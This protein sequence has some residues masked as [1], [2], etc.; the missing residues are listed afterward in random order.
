[1]YKEFFEIG[2]C[3]IDSVPRIGLFDSTEN[4]D[5]KLKSH[6]YLAVF[7]DDHKFHGILTPFDLLE[8]PY[9]LVVDCLSPKEH[10][11]HSDSFEIILEKFKKSKCFAL[12]VFCDND[13]RGIIEKERVLNDFEKKLKTYH[14]KSQESEEIK[15]SF[16]YNLSHEV[17]TPLNGIIG[18]MEIIANLEKEDLFEKRAEYL[19]II[20]NSASRFLLVMD[21]V[22]LLSKLTNGVQ[23]PLNNTKVKIEKIFSELFVYFK[24]MTFFGPKKPEIEYINPDKNK[25]III[26]EEKLKHILYHLIDNAIK[27]SDDNKAIF[28]YDISDDNHGI[29]FFVENHY[30]KEQ[31]ING[32][33]E[34]FKEFYKQPEIN[35]HINPGFGIGLSLVKRLT[36]LLGGKI[37]LQNEYQIM[38]FIVKFPIS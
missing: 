24:E 16:L 7:D 34:I 20:K 35:G 6:R 3:I 12:P 9:K 5:K 27:F 2:N 29:N 17:R 11:E 21:D 18:F 22:I 31:I 25:H 8:R 4:I 38:K 32:S 14:R 36:E 13:F 1:M 19:K 30:S 28:G 15:K 26:D 37:V 23:I 33:E 10:I